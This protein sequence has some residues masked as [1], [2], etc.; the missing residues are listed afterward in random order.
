MQSWSAALLI[1][2]LSAIPARSDA[3]LKLYV[4]NQQGTYQDNTYGGAMWGTMTSLLDGAFGAGNVSQFADL[5]NLATLMTYDRLWL[6]QRLGG[7]LS[8]TEY[9]N[10]AAFLATGRRAV[11]I[12]ENDLWIPWNAQLASL[13]GG[14]ITS[15]CDYT[16]AVPVL[17]HAITAGVTSV[18]PA[19][20]SLASGGTNLFSTG[21]A[22]LWGSNLST[23]LV[24]DANI[25]DDFYGAWADNATFNA[26]TASWLA[27]SSVTATPEPASLLLVATGLAGVT[28]VVRRRRRSA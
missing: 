1:V 8:A 18:D 19:C 13:V 4:A 16:S 22:T 25:Q 2:G 14:T 23:L 15:T 24:L 20:T 6:D 21:F 7:T 9:S 3:Q 17:A 12:G 11:L 10:V 26:N 28:A 27:A 5:N